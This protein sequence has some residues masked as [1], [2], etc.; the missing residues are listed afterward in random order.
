MNDLRMRSKTSLNPRSE[1]K[2]RNT[3]DTSRLLSDAVLAC[4]AFAVKNWLFER[5]VGS[6]WLTERVLLCAAVG[7]VVKLFFGRK[8]GWKRTEWSLLALSSFLNFIRILSFCAA[9]PRLGALRL[10][11]FT[12]LTPTWIQSIVSPSSTRAIIASSLA[13]GFSVLSDAGW[14]VHQLHNH[15][16]A[17]GFLLLNALVTWG[18]EHT[19]HALSPGMGGQ[20]AAGASLVGALICAVP[21][22]FIAVGLG[23]VHPTPVLP[24]PSLLAIL[25]L[26]A[27][28]FL[29]PGMGPE[30]TTRA[31]LPLLVAF[32]IGPILF[33]SGLGWMDFIVAGLLSYGASHTQTRPLTKTQPTSRLLRSYLK[34]I[35]E[36]PESRKIFYFLVL[37]MCYML[38]QMLYGI[39]TNSLG[40]I[41]DAIH[42]A[43]DCM[44]IGVGLFASVMATWPANDKFTYGYGRIETLSG[45]AN[46][47]FL[48]LISIFI[49]FEAIQRLLDPPEMNTSQLLLVSGLGLGV[50]LFGMFAMGGH[51]HGHSHGGHSHGHSHGG[52]HS[53]SS[54]SHPQASDDHGHSHARD[55]HGHSH[56]H[57]DHGHSHERRE[58]APTVIVNGANGHG[59]GQRD[60]DCENHSH[61]GEHGHSHNGDHGHS[62]NGDHGHSHDNHEHSRSTDH[63]HSHHDDHGHSHNGAG[64]HGHSH[65]GSSH[66]L[67]PLHVPY[68]NSTSSPGPPLSPTL[69]FMPA[70]MRSPSPPPV[71]PSYSYYSNAHEDSGSKAHNHDHDHGQS[72]NMRGVFL[73]VMADTLG[74]VGVIISTLLIQWYGWT[75]FDPIA[76]LFIAILIAASVVPLVMDCAKVLSLDVGERETS[77]RQALIELSNV[78]GL[79]SYSAPRFWPK[80]GESLVGSIHIQLAPSASSY[81]PAGAHRSQRV[82]YV[83]ADRVVDRVEQLLRARIHGLDA[84]TIQVEGSRDQPWCSCLNDLGA[85]RSV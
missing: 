47:I 4:G 66:G 85:G 12:Y 14:A 75:G 16:P 42:M 73:H 43:F 22:H 36:N 50:N 33:R 3:Q 18:Y 2:T 76:S 1:F 54:S 51:H 57:D 72:H 68:R 31:T 8:S 29:A 34:T 80:D 25:I 77:I 26:A 84:L 52:G 63:G 39:W 19:I 74:S 49:I 64:G 69:P 27:G 30:T 55:D 41:S 6:V 78:D 13:L 45:F 48:I 83:N 28:F 70:N 7:V 82:T 67:A 15:A 24:L 32:F 61:D 79:A 46:G 38:V 62:H 23:A 40:L 81:D 59:H 21:G 58:S 9:L 11:V 71:A 20:A 60:D 10:L 53:H 56:G 35:L 37:N 17:Y 44:A 65:D 5:G